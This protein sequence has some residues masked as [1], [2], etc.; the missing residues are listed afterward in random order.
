GYSVREIIAAVQKIGKIRIPTAESPRRAGDPAEL[1]SDP[2]KIMQD[3][4]WQ[5]DFDDIEKIVESA[6]HWEKNR[7]F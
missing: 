3:L 5:P 7:T 6:Y 2:K 1:V 4:D